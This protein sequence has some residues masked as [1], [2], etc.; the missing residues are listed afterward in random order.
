MPNKYTGKW[1]DGQTTITFDKL[2]DMKED[3]I[4]KLGMNDDQV[5]ALSLYCKELGIIFFGL[6]GESD[7]SNEEITK[8]RS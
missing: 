1:N 7:F 3:L 8:F 5:R 6:F 4:K 2:F